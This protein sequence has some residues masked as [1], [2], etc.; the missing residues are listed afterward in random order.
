MTRGQ[1]GHPCRVAAALL[2]ISLSAA[3][4]ASRQP[5]ATRKPPSPNAGNPARTPRDTPPVP[6]IPGA[7]VEEGFAS[8]YG[9]P[10][11]RRRAANGEIYDMYQMTA[12]HRTLPFESV[13]RVTNLK[14][15]RT[16]EVRINDRGPFV[17][18]RVIDL[19]LAAAREI[20]MVAAG[21]APVRLELLSGAGR[22]EGNFTVQ[23]GAFLVRENA[24]RLRERLAQRYAHVST[25]EY[26][27]PSGLFYRVRVGRLASQE[28]A[29]RLA[30]QLRAEE[31]VAPFV[32]R[33]DE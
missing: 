25:I 11:H 5:R 32:V 28:E 18:N 14:N 19:S 20:D 17:E 9:V 12:A 21:V 8:W 3:S 23:I 7:Y 27:S 26:D 16:A 4:C 1:V 24:A 6:P 31:S 13:V 15:G 30:E 33:L 2:L 10:Y 22:L 29:R